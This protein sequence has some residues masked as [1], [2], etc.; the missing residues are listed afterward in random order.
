MTT[1]EARITQLVVQLDAM[2]ALPEVAPDNVQND[3]R[4]T[5]AD[6]AWFNSQ[7]AKMTGSPVHNPFLIEQ[8]LI[9]SINQVRTTYN[10]PVTVISISL[11]RQIT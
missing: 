2:L 7:L 6:G 10:L 5:V 11:E 8:L 4:F 3:G 9:A 1:A